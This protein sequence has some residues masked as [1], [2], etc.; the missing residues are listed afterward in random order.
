MR[1]PPTRQTRAATERRRWTW[2]GTGTTTKADKDGFGVFLDDVAYVFAETAFVGLPALYLVMRSGEPSFVGPTVSLSVAWIAM[3][4][5]GALIRGGW[6]S[7]LATD[8]HGWVSLDSTLVALRVVYYNALMVGVAALG[9]TLA[10]GCPILS[11]LCPAVVG[12]AAMLLFPALSDRV[13]AA[14][15]AG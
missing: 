12:A 13:Y 11:L 15:K 5:T 14:V 8:V 2:Y 1:G 7:P 6:I 3:V 10:P 4:V 9:G